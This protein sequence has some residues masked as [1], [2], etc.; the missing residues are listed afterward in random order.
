MTDYEVDPDEV[1]DPQIQR[2]AAWTNLTPEAVLSRLLDDAIPQAYTNLKQQ[3]EQQAQ[4]REQV[5]RAAAQEAVEGEDNAD[6]DTDTDAEVK[7]AT[8]GGE[9]GEGDE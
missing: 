1:Y 6:T 2:L 7:A 8:D 3:R 9:G 4:Q 5:A